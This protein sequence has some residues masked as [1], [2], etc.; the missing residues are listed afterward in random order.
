MTNNNIFQN[1]KNPIITFTEYIEK[2]EKMLEKNRKIKKRIVIESRKL[3]MRRSNLRT[4]KS[5]TV[6]KKKKK[7][8]R[9]P[10]KQANSICK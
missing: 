10:R 6:I 5:L 8:Y 3:K 1:Q 7:N 2:I 4:S 9:S